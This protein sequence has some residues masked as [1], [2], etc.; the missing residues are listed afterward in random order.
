M[1]RRHPG[2]TRVVYEVRGHRSEGGGSELGD[3]SSLVRSSCFLPYQTVNSGTRL[4]RP[5]GP[6]GIGTARN[7][8]GREHTTACGE[9]GIME[10]STPTSTRATTSRFAWHHVN[11]S[12]DG[13]ESAR[14]HDAQIDPVVG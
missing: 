5:S 1:G 7:Y 2:M 4:L 8:L 9:C 14:A 10:R 6:Q 3:A 13:D 11:D 12:T